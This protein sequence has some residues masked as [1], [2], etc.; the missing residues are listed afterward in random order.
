MASPATIPIPAGST[1]EPIQ[2]ATSAP[3][4]VPIPAG[5]TLEALPQGGAEQ[6]KEGLFHALGSDLLGIVKS[7]PH[8]LPPVMAYDKAKEFVANYESMRDTGKTL[9]ERDADER[10]KA[11]HG[12]AYQI[13]AGVN[14]Q[15]GVNVKGEEQAADRG[16][17]GGVIGHA[18]A[19]PVAMAATEGAVKGGTALANAA[20]PVAGAAAETLYRSA[21]KPST[22]IPVEQSSRMVKTALDNNIP[23]SPDGLDKLNALQAQ[24]NKTIADTIASDPNATVS[25]QA[26]AQR[27]RQTYQNVSQQVSPTPDINRVKKVS[28]DFAQNNPDQIPAAKAQAMKQGTYQ[29]IKSAAYG[30]M[31]TATVEAQKALARGIKEELEKQFPEIK[32]LNAQEGRLLELDPVLE[33][34]VNR[35]GNHNMIGIGTPIA[36]AAGA[37]VGGPVGAAIAATLKAVVDNPMVKTRL[38]VA[39]NRASKG[40]V[41]VP[42]ATARIAAYSSAL[43]AGASSA[44]ESD[45][46]KSQTP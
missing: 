27:L 14:E 3:Q 23:I 17:I 5:S 37:S 33:R 43:G 45:A 44:S 32:G 13:G 40:T 21:L 42:A 9:A 12:R 41:S 1:L 7:A 30:E 15:L 35:I 20:K 11:G 18:A 38:A 26:V 36:S 2:Q 10:A 25:K 16:D 22:T 29:S 28:Y 19:V 34:A 8:M 39:L 24:V 6:P 4:S 31:K 46:Q